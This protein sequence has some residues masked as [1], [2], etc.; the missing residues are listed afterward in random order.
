MSVSLLQVINR[1]SLGTK[2]SSPTIYNLRRI[3]YFNIVL[4]E[5]SDSWIPIVYY[6]GLVSVN[7]RTII[8]FL[9]KSVSVQIRVTSGSGEYYNTFLGREID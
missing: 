5:D 1:T 9:L 2:S 7:G 4:I 3:I 6:I 8:V